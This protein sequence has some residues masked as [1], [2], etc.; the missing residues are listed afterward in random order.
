[1]PFQKW[2]GVVE[3]VIF[4]SQQYCVYTRMFGSLPYTIIAH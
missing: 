1:L 4:V 3:L 2:T